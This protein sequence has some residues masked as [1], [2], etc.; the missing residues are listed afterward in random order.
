V[1][2]SLVV[3]GTRAHSLPVDEAKQYLSIDNQS[4]HI[5]KPFFCLFVF[6]F[7]WPS[8]IVV[9][10]VYSLTVCVCVCVYVCLSSSPTPSAR[11]MN[12]SGAH[13]TRTRRLSHACRRVEPSSPLNPNS[14]CVRLFFSS[15]SSSQARMYV[16][17]LICSHVDV[18]ARACKKKLVDVRSCIF[19]ISSRSPL[20]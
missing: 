11:S 4:I 5:S 14:I 6:S 17:F 18:R 15:S 8:D 16:C 10:G 20:L 1:N 3:D 19:C 2:A 12:K 9:S 7:C 13:D